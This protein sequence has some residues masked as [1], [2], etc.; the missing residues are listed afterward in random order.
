ML[1]ERGNYQDCAQYSPPIFPYQ[2]DMTTNRTQVLFTVPLV[3]LLLAGCAAQSPASQ[4]A[5]KETVRICQ[6][7]TC[8]NQHRSVSTFQGEAANVEAERRIQALTRLAEQDPKAAYDL[9][10]RLLRGD[11]VEHN[12]Y[13]AMEW[14]RKSGDRGY[15]PA[16]VSLGRLYLTGVEE[17]GSDPAE[18]QSWFS[19][20][21]ARGD[22]ESQRLLALV[23]GA[24]ADEQRLYQ[25]RETSRKSWGNW[26][27]NEPY[28]WSWEA[29]GWHRY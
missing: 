15:L 4:I 9:G 1:A 24:K 21:A 22:R 20:A 7:N 14:L 18:A 25:I 19:R 29:D 5:G 2:D 12:S 3:A 16:Q 26:Y 17:M 13:Q 10:M 8:A 23:Q 27:D 11:G 28:Y 6:G